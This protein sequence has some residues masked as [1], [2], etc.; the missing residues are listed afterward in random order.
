MQV[1]VPFHPLLLMDVFS[2]CKV[3]DSEKEKV[4]SSSKLAK[5]T[6]N[7]KALSNPPTRRKM[8]QGVMESD[9]AESEEQK[10]NSANNM[11]EAD[12]VNE[13]VA[14]G[15]ELL[16]SP[17]EKTKRR[18]TITEASSKEGVEIEDET[19]SRPR[20]GQRRQS[21]NEAEGDVSKGQEEET[22]LRRS[23]RKRKTISEDATTTPLEGAVDDDALD[24]TDEKRSSSRRLTRSL[25][26]K[27]SEGKSA[28]ESQEG[29]RRSDGGEE[30][31]EGRSLRKRSGTPQE[32]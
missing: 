17:L 29:L 22:N 12:S 3:S 13:T 27:S 24:D 6:R 28:E 4:S 8:R 31:K 11:S 1:R 14:N 30:K 25:I 7:T 10:I 19:A 32:E 26:S 5:I 16:L 23:G 15:D 2:L 18:Q 20:R 21:T 9:G